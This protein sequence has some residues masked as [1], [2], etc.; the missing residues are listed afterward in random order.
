LNEMYRLRATAI[1][2]FKPAIL[3]SS[4]KDEQVWTGTAHFFPSLSFNSFHL[5]ERFRISTYHLP[6]FHT[7]FSMDGL[8]SSLALNSITLLPTVSDVAIPVKKA[9]LAVAIHSAKNSKEKS[10][11]EVESNERCERCSHDSTDMCRG[12]RAWKVLH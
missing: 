2:Q 9:D 10:N 8:H 5:I 6:H 1:F 4:P 12:R 3:E 11:N 7:H